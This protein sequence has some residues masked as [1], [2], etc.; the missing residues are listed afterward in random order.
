MRV[1]AFALRNIKELL[2]DPLSYIFCLGFPII[3]LIVMTI[4]NG[5]IPETVVPE[6]V[7]IPEGTSMAPTVFQIHKLTPAITVFGLSFLSLFCCMRVSSDRSS[8]FLMRLYASPMKGTDYIVGYL[9]PFALIAFSQIIITY[10]A[11]DIIALAAGKNT[12]NVLYML[13]SLPLLIPS[14]LLFISLGIIFGVLFNDKAAPGVC[15]TMI[16]A[17]A[18]LGGIWMDVDQMGGVWLAICNKLPFYHSVKAARL[19]LAGD[20][21]GMLLPLAI[22]SSFALVLFVLSVFTFVRKTKSDQR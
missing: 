15:S 9:L 19:A 20:F 7:P 10:T 5:S 17:A 21:G 22:C 14:I 8:A 3:M 16:T 11:G 13:L 1:M 12:F 18:L 6:G 2:R 4:V